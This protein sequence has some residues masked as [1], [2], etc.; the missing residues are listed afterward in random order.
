MRTTIRLD[1]ELLS[2]AKAYAARHRR[3]LA[4]VLE[5]ALR[6]HLTVAEQSQRQ[7][8]SV[9][10]TSTAGGG[11]RPG[12]DL[13]DTATLLDVMDARA[14]TGCSGVRAEGIDQNVDTQ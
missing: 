14:T 7:P 2:Q 11:T 9:L 3:T 8:K 12:V 4:S 13:D 5:E 1:D 6:L 10:P